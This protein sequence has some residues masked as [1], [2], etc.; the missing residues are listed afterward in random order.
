[1]GFRTQ[2]TTIVYLTEQSR[3]SFRAAL[4]KAGLSNRSD[5]VVLFWSQTYGFSWEE[6]ISTVRTECLRLGAKL[7]IIDTFPQFAGLVG[8]QENS[9]G[10]TLKFLRPLQAL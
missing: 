8:D 5:L 10:E 7:L 3:K 2:K 9:S 6:V 4:A 1:M